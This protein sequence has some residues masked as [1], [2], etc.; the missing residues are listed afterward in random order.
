[1]KRIKTLLI[2]SMVI[3]LSFSLFG[4]KLL[5]WGDSAAEETAVI[6]EL[7]QWLTL[8]HRAEAAEEPEMEEEEVAE[9]EEEAS[10]APAPAATTQPATTQPATTQPAQ[11]SGTPKWQQPGT[12]EYIGKLELDR[13]VEEY[14][15]LLSVV[16][17]GDTDANAARL[18]EL[19]LSIPK[20]A[21]GLAIHADTFKQIYGITA[22]YT[23]TG[24][25]ANNDW[26]HEWDESPSGFGGDF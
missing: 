16:K 22:P 13:L 4:C 14:K 26:F 12:M 17:K 9:E 10:E 18:A 2:F 15:S 3:A 25:T 24:E 1:M 20:I 7:P 11:T 6:A 23:A 5:P 21:A 19:K 8:A